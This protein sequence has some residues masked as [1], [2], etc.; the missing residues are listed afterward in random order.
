MKVGKAVI[1]AEIIVCFPEESCDD[2]FVFI[3][4]VSDT[5]SKFC[6]RKICRVGN[7]TNQKCRNSVARKVREIF[8]NCRICGIS[9]RHKERALY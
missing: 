1:L 5:V 2:Y 9:D 4:I 6:V 7:I 8:L 3:G